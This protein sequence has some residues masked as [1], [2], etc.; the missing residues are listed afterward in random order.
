M[1]GPYNNKPALYCPLC[2]IKGDH[3]V[4]RCPKFEF[5]NLKSATE[6]QK[7]AATRLQQTRTKR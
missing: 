6:E 4:K 5:I 1:N 3:P 7:V 2:D